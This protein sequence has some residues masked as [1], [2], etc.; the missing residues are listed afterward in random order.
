M[1]F[2]I[3]CVF[4][5]VA[6]TVRLDNNVWANSET[7]GVQ[8]FNFTHYKLWQPF[9]IQVVRTATLNKTF[10]TPTL[11]NIGV[12]DQ[13]GLLVSSN[14]TP[15]FLIVPAKYNSSQQKDLI[16]RQEDYLVTVSSLESFTYNIRACM[17]K[18][19][20]TELAGCMV[21]FE[22]GDAKSACEGNGACN[23]GLCVCDHINWQIQLE[24]L[25]PSLRWVAKLIGKADAL[26]NAIL[27]QTPC[28]PRADATKVL[29][30]LKTALIVFVVVLICTILLLLG[31]CLACCRYCRK[32]KDDSEGYTALLQGDDLYDLNEAV[33]SYEKN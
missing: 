15:G 10:P 7:S 13:S 33:D 16:G 4:T 22:A 19:S 27:W 21:N 8:I 32:P 1:L 9:E 31:L 6:A 17:G 23:N 26:F 18:C 12:K 25:P 30:H 3:F 11:L 29:S 2:P 24:D 28:R 20:N 5:L 14:S